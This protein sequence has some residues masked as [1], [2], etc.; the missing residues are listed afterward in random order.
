MLLLIGITF[1]IVVVASVLMGAVAY[2]IYVER[3]VAALRAGPHRPES[4]RGRVRHSLRPAAAAG[5]RSQ[6]AAQRG[7]RADLRQQAA[8][9]PGAR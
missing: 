3:K 4:G 8:L 1:K 6:D 5:R 2:L 9:Y 7:G